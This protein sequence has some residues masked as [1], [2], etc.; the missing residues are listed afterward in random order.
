[1][2]A[3][4]VVSNGDKTAP[5]GGQKQKLLPDVVVDDDGLTLE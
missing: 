1:M 3:R 5:D 2:D 4:F